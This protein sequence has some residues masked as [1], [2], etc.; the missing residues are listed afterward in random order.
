MEA[1]FVFHR[2][3]V[4]LLCSLN[5]TIF[6]CA[7]TLTAAPVKTVWDSILGH[8]VQRVGQNC[9]SD[10]DAASSYAGLQV[11]GRRSAGKA[12]PAET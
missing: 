10:T 5:G 2:E 11:G 8:I 4:Y 1:S 3:V 6:N 7:V 9:G 12:C